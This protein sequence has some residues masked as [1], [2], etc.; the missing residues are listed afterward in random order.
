MVFPICT[1]TVLLTNAMIFFFFLN[2]RALEGFLLLILLWGCLDS[3]DFFCVTKCALSNNPTLAQNFQDPFP[4]L[5]Q[6][7][8]LPSTSLEALILPSGIS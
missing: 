1:Q 4:G 3:T 8:N 7:S 5:I 6:P 2:S